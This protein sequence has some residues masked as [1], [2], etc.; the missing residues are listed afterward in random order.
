MTD[1]VVTIDQQFNGPNVSANGG[2]TCGV[3]SE[4]LPAGQAHTCRLS[5]PPPLDTPMQITVVEGHVTMK[6]GDQVIGT[7]MSDTLEIAPPPPP[8]DVSV[9]EAA[10]TPIMTSFDFLRRCYVCGPDRHEGGLHIHPAKLA[11]R[12]GEVACFWQTKDAH[13]GADGF[14]TARQLWSALDCPGYFACAA[15]KPALL[16]QMTGKI[17]GQVRAGEAVKVHAWTK[18][19]MGRKCRAGVALYAPDDQL[20]AAADQ[21]WVV[22]KDSMFDSLRGATV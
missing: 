8:S 17:I 22:V 3:L 7:V 19:V 12:D 21:L 18:S 14:V 4:F 20:I 15:G 11:G 2:Y 6:D 13:A 10:Q 16:G 9:F 5:A 1:T